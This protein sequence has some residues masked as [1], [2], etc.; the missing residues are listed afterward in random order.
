M[1]K[2]T[3]K[4]VIELLEKIVAKQ[5]EGLAILMEQPPQYS[6]EVKAKYIEFVKHRLEIQ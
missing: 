3:E 5:N 4:K 6:P 2:R 1:T